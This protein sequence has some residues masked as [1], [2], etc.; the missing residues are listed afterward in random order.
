MSAPFKMKHQGS[1]FN[2]FGGAKSS[3]AKFGFWKKMKDM[4]SRGNA[5]G[6][7][8]A[9]EEG[10]NEDNGRISQTDDSVNVPQHGAESHGGGGMGRGRGFMG[11]FGGGGGG[12]MS[13][14]FQHGR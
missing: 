7:D 13:K 6:D 2:M 8:L 3:P 9:M 1:P 4:F 11:L 5:G 12:G 14:W 10:L